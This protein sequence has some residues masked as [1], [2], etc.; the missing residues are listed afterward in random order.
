VP[1]TP[2]AT[3]ISAAVNTIVAVINQTTRTAQIAATPRAPQA[4][5]A[6]ATGGGTAPAQTGDTGAKADSDS[7]KTSDASAGASNTTGVKSA[8]DIKKTYCN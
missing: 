4:V 1:V 3:G 2:P 5:V 7:E 6:A 8:K